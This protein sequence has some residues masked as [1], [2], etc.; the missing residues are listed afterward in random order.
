MRKHLLSVVCMLLAGCLFLTACG[1][2][3]SSNPDGSESA[4]PGGT[5]DNASV[6]TSGT[7]DTQGT[8][9]ATS[10][11]AGGDTTT[12]NSGEATGTQGTGTPT[13]GGTTTAK[14]TGGNSSTT[15]KTQATTTTTT[16]KV[17][18][19]DGKLNVKDGVLYQPKT[20]KYNN[21]IKYRNTLANTYSKLTTGKKL[22]VVYFGGSVTVG[23]GASNQDT[24]SWRALIGQ[25]LKDSFPNAEVTN[26][27]R[28]TGESG[29]YLGSYRFQ[30][31]VVEAKPDLV[32]I[33]YSINDLYAAATYQQAASQYEA[34][35]RGIR[36][37][38][39][40]CDIV[41]IL[42]T[43]Q[44]RANGQLHEQAKAHEDVSIAYGIPTVHV[45]R[46]LAMYLIDNCETDVWSNYMI[47]IVHP[48]DKGYNFY[49]EVIRE[50]M[51][52]CLKD[53]KHDG[54]VK[55]YTVPAQQ[56]DVLHNGNVTAIMPSQDLITRS[57]ALGGTGFRFV[58]DSYG[59]ANYPTYLKSDSKG[60]KLV[61]E[62]TGT[63]LVM[64][65]YASALTEFY[66]TVDGGQ[67]VKKKF[68][69]THDLSLNPTIMVTDLP[70]GKHTV[71]I[72]PINTLGP[73]SVLKIG[74]FFSRDAAKASR[75]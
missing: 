68:V 1:G 15:Q 62:F 4:L 52:A 32:F 34:I 41:T 56:C 72:E 44:S 10:T 69:G 14:P 20:G 3:T 25:W 54:K 12:A 6:T 17:S 45:G 7:N 73:R 65:N 5:T 63:E 26:L 64:L 55:K 13:T 70:S 74:A 59:L 36:Q 16:T 18:G 24:K 67:R 58:N 39:P 31:D 47:D 42:V 35:V 40:E 30:R 71:I 66:I 29:T 61:L 19:G 43:D 48:N 46:A 9:D 50:F 49:Y 51:T 23:Y 53:Y 27:N 28:G 2:E 75:K 22:N 57:E 60:S 37:Q 33:E 38:L 8:E 21:Y 11:D